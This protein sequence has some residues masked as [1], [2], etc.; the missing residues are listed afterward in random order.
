MATF[1]YNNS[2]DRYVNTSDD[3]IYFFRSQKEDTTF[4]KW[5]LR[6]LDDEQNVMICTG[7]SIETHPFNTTYEKPDPDNSKTASSTTFSISFSNT[8]NVSTLH[9]ANDHPSPGGD[10][11]IP[12]VFAELERAQLENHRDFQYKTFYDPTTEYGREKVVSSEADTVNYS[13]TYSRAFIS[14]FPDIGDGT[15][16]ALWNNAGYELG[17]SPDTSIPGITINNRINMSSGQAIG[18][19]T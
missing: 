12:D 13:P 14:N 9:N 4:G 18:N 16:Q 11:V 5:H 10:G 7:T 1:S 15:D 2:T 17:P 8:T 19:Y 6:L 3:R